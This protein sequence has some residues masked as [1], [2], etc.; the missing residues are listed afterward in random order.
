MKYETKYKIIHWVEKLLG[1]SENYRRYWVTDRIISKV[2]IMRV[3]TTMPIQEEKMM[4]QEQIEYTIGGQ[5]L[6]ELQRGEFIKYDRIP[7][8]PMYD[9][10]MVQIEATLR[11]I[12]P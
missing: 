4:T 5:I 10:P 11:V 8:A 2:E 7:L 1:I 3:V 12:K 9:K 6:H